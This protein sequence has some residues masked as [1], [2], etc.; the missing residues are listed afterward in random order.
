M[1]PYK[2][3]VLWSQ[4]ELVAAAIRDQARKQDLA[5]VKDRHAY[6]AGLL[7]QMAQADGQEKEH[8]PGDR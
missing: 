4:I 5:M 7:D 3:A 6:L 8:L 2:R 1:T